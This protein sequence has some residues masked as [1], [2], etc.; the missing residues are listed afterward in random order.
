MCGLPTFGDPDDPQPEH[1]DGG[2]N[3]GQLIPWLPDPDRCPECD[4]LM[5]ADTVWDPREAR[6]VH[7]W[8]CPAC[9]TSTRR[10]PEHHDQDAPQPSRGSAK[11]RSLFT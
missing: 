7:A 2:I 1:E 9:D 6:H 5:Q 10:D 4:T 3:V 8:T 11:L